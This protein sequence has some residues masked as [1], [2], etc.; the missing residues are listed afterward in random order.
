[1]PHCPCPHHRGDLC[2]CQRVALRLYKPARKP[3]TLVVHG[4]DGHTNLSLQPDFERA[5]AG[6]IEAVLSG[7][8]SSAA[9]KILRENFP[10]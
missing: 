10:A 9:L 5:A 4:K 7:A 1:M 6:Q 2:A 3:F 8:F